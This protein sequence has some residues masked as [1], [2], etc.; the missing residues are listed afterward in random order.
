MNEKQ[1]LRFREIV[2][3]HPYQIWTLITLKKAINRLLPSNLTV[4]VE[5]IAQHIKTER[6]FQVFR[7]THNGIMH[8]LFIKKEKN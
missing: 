7:N 1:I 8:Y 6:E 4:K 3:N 5:N 2:T